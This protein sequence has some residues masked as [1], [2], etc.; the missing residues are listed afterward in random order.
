MVAPAMVV[1]V[2]LRPGRPTG[3]SPDPLLQGEQDSFVVRANSI[4]EGGS[5]DRAG[6]EILLFGPSNRSRGA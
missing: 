5:T 2:L 1:D 4:G 6:A 3:P